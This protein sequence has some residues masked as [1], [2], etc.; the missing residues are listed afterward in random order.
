MKFGSW[1]IP[2]IFFNPIKSHSFYLSRASFIK[3][4]GTSIIASATPIFT[5]VNSNNDPEEEEHV[6]SSHHF[7]QSAELSD[8]L[9]VSS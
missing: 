3:N 1:I 4:T 9:V 7:K 8:V 5:W 2:L 6:E